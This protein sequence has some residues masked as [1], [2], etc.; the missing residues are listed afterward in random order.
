MSDMT[1]GRCRR[2]GCFA[3]Q[4]R[5]R[6]EVDH[7][8]RIGLGPRGIAHVPMYVQQRCKLLGVEMATP[9]HCLFCADKSWNDQA[10]DPL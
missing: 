7:P 8:L 9:F 1:I 4:L 5:L 10:L 2:F 3:E 6:R